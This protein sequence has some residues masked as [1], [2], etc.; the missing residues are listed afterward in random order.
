MKMKKILLAIT[1]VGILLISAASVCVTA[2]V[3]KKKVKG[4]VVRVFSGSGGSSRFSDKLELST[5]GSVEE[6][7]VF[8]VHVFDAK[9]GRAVAAYVS[10]NGQTKYGSYV[11]FRAP[12][13]SKNTYM[14]VSA[15]RSG[16]VGDSGR[17]LVKDWIH[18]MCNC[19]KK[20]VYTLYAIKNKVIL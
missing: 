5:P 11:V 6:R 18:P 17:I 12:A 3:A 9:D 7:K 13:V 2:S 10:F 14:T 1:I 19:L 4:E 8:S 16:W 15:H 20:R